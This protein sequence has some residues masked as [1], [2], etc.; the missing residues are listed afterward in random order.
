M[1]IVR[2]ICNT[3]HCGYLSVQ[4]FV[5]WRDSHRKTNW[6]CIYI[7]MWPL[8]QPQ[9]LFL[10]WSAFQTGIN[11][12]SFG[13]VNVCTKGVWWGTNCFCDTQ[14]KEEW[15]HDESWKSDREVQYEVCRCLSNVSCHSEF[16][17]FRFS[18]VWHVLVR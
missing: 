16:S 13:F 2:T 17:H 3:V 12:W 9:I 11:V 10:V 6:K 8:Y 15:G 18:F 7:L 4:N 5:L 14:L 1:L